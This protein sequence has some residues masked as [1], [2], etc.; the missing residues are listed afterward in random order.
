ML[1]FE[2]ANNEISISVFSIQKNMKAATI[3][4]LKRIVKSDFW[5]IFIFSNK[6]TEIEYN[7]SIENYVFPKS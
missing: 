3:L 4:H 6:T 5:I 2:F 1:R 7:I